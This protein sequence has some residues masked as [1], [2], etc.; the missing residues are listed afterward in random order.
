MARLLSLIAYCAD[1]KLMYCP[2]CR[3]ETIFKES[4]WNAG[5]WICSV[6]RFSVKR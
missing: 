5:T 4:A 2:K 6:C 3:K 1:G